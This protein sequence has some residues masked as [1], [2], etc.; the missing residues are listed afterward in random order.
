M[1][2]A[3]SVILTQ[4]TGYICED[5]SHDGTMRKLGLRDEFGGK[6]QVVKAELTPPSLFDGR[7]DYLAP[8]ERWEFS[9]RQDNTPD[10]YNPDD[11]ELRTRRL[12]EKWLGTH[13]VSEGIVEG[14]SEGTLILSGA[15]QSHGQVGGWCYCYASAQSHGQVG[16]WCYC[17]DTAQ[18]HGQA[19]GWCNLSQPADAGEEGE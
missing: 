14:W 10:W 13:H 17:Y 19:G 5:D 3:V 9:V 16:G 4:E 12:A 7:L 15:A 1:C 8:L 18:S 6:I 2:Q 11:A